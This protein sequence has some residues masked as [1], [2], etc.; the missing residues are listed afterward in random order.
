MH[1]YTF[2]KSVGKISVKTGFS[3]DM[4]DVKLEVIEQRPGFIHS[5][6]TYPNGYILESKQWPDKI[7][8]ISS[9]PIDVDEDG[10]LFINMN[11]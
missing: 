2:D 7:E 5:V 11:R 4:S 10:S 6:S 9:H 8:I 1:K 3:D